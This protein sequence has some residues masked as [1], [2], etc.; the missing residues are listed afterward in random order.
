MTDASVIPATVD[1]QSVRKLARHS[2]GLLAIL[3]V[4]FGVSVIVGNSIGSGILRTP[5]EVARLLPTPA[6]FLG[7]WVLGALYAMLGANVLAELA[8]MMPESGGYTVYLRRSLGLYGGFIM[9]WNDWLATCASAALGA[10]VIGEYT[11]IL[12][13]L[14]KGLTNAIAAGAILFFALIQWRGIK[15]GSL[16]QNLT[17]LVKTI[18]FVILIGACFWLGSG[19]LSSGGKSPVPS[20]FA[21]FVP[22]VLAMQAVIFS[23]DGYNG[24]CYFAGELRNPARDIPRSIFGGVIAVAAIYLLMNVGFLYVLPL[25]RM[26]G[27]P[28]V[29]A[30]ATKAMFGANGDT[31]IRVLTIVSLLSAMNA[32]ELMTSR[33]LYRLG[34]FG[35]GTRARYVNTGGTPAIALLLSTIVML[36]LAI[37]GTVQIVI[38]VTAFFFVAQYVLIVLSVFILRRREP[39]SLRPFKA[40][41]HPWTTGLFLVLSLAML[42]GD[43]ATDTRNSI[44]SIIL[45]AL[46]WPVYLMVRPKAKIV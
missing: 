18:A 29:A 23:Y 3:G 33:V 15:E 45:L 43:V 10:L 41:G 21:F 13:G 26:A 17:A 25:D 39:D 35:F 24:V 42:V 11:T 38:A 7:V 46:S 22:F 5:G 8:T 31:V 44:Y 16:T 34:M 37:T 30:T 14:Q 40:K 20:G 19:F 36:G 27:E 1:Q 32:W 28:L 2:G 9:G 4:A 6:L 12:L